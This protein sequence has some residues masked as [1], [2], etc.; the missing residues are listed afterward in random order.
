M[1]AS[2]DFLVLWVWVSH[3]YTFHNNSESSLNLKLSPRSED[4]LLAHPWRWTKG[5][6][7][8]LGVQVHPWGQT[9]PLGANSCC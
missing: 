4:P 6:T 3:L 1:Y 2:F 5:W 9:S 8:P 7:F